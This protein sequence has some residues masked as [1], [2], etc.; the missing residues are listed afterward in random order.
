MAPVHLTKQTDVAT[1][2]PSASLPAGRTPVVE[3]AQAAGA[4]LGSFA[5]ASGGG[6]GLGGP[7]LGFIVAAM[8]GTVL[9]MNA[10][11]GQAEE[12]YRASVAALG[13]FDGR[14]VRIELALGVVDDAAK[15]LP[16]I[17]RSLE[18][19]VEDQRKAAG[20]IESLERLIKHSR[21]TDP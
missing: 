14:L 1:S 4:S 21:S 9:W 13:T 5:K 2:D 20:A 15:E 19:L 11:V 3:L 17:R 16:E 12:S 10:R 18:R 7:V 8:I 6:A